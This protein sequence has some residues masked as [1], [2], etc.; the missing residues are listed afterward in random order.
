MDYQRCPSDYHTQIYKNTI[1]Y[2]YFS[3][4]QI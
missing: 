4:V 2:E 3:Q 1:F